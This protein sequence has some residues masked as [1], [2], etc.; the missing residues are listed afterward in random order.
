M[1]FDCDIYLSFSSNRDLQPGMNSW[2]E[3]FKSDLHYFLGKISDTKLKILTSTDFVNSEKN[4]KVPNAAVYIAM[5]GSEQEL[6]SEYIEELGLI[7]SMVENKAKDYFMIP[8]IFKIVEN[9]IQV[10]NQPECIRQEYNYQFFGYDKVTRKY[11]KFEQTKDSSL[12]GSRYWTGIIDL[13]H[14]ILNSINLI[15][16]AKTS[17]FVYLAETTPDQEQNRQRIK[18]ELYRNGFLVVPENRLTTDGKKL[19]DAIINQVK[20]TLFTIHIIGSEYGE[21]L[22]GTYQSMVDFQIKT[23]KE[24]INGTTSESTHPQQIIWIPSGIKPT[25]EK[26]K[27]FIERIKRDNK[28]SYTEI[29]ISSIQ[30]INKLISNRI[31]KEVSV[32]KLS[33][34]SQ[35][36]VYLIQPDIQS[37]DDD[38]CQTIKSQLKKENLVCLELNY[39]QDNVVQ[40]HFKLLNKCDGVILCCGKNQD[41]IIARH[42]DIIKSAGIRSSQ[43]QPKKAMLVKKSQDK[44]I[45]EFEDEYILLTTGDNLKQ[46]LKKFLSVL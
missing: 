29:I 21:Y 18:R 22:K 1:S 14:D 43:C 11:I 26:Q 13:S 37:S 15:Q 7:K 36:M 38:A 20:D 19:K 35:K 45:L 44:K 16:G 9:M 31:N 10:E 30:E 39:N 42:R 32:R 24:F 12:K 2:L 46:D 34:E 40:E 33:L 6:T 25:S 41:W 23:V 8:R 3:G 5:L 17:G 28:T 27:L 4:F